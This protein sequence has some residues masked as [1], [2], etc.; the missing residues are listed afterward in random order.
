MLRFTELP[1]MCLILFSPSQADSVH[2]RTHPA[3]PLWRVLY[4][5]F[6][7]TFLYFPCVA[8][9]LYC[10]QCNCLLSSQFSIIPE[11]TRKLHLS[12]LQYVKLS[13]V[14][15][16]LFKEPNCPTGLFLHMN[17]SMNT[18]SGYKQSKYQQL[19]RREGLWLL[20][21]G[22]RWIGGQRIYSLAR[23]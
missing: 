16:W 23:G 21:T 4:S 15:N 5:D 20:A 1:S 9:I 14:F 7:I 3:A 10:P 17:S 19:R 2:I 22:C 8:E 6:L 11:H 18:S 13:D 12:A